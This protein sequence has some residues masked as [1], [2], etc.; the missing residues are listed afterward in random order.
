MLKA[1]AVDVWNRI[2]L[3]YMIAEGQLHKYPQV[4]RSDH[5]LVVRQDTWLISQ[6]TRPRE[7]S[8]CCMI[9]PVH[10]DLLHSIHV[11]EEFSCR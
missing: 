6:G 7:G 8:K 9:A 1:T 10:V 5:T 2:L 11:E 4:G 3:A